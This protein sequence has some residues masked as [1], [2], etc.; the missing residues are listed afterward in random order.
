MFKLA[1]RIC[2]GMDIAYFFE[3]QASH[4]GTAAIVR[5]QGYYRRVSGSWEFC[6]GSSSLEQTMAEGLAE[7]LR[8]QVN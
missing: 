3:F 8:G 7:Y 2:F 4:F 1:C 5:S 6:K